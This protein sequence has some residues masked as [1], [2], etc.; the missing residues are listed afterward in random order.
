MCIFCKIINNEIPSNKI[1]EDDEILAILD[2]SQTEVGGHKG[3][4]LVMPKKHYANVLEIPSDELSNIMNKVQTLAKMI[5]SKLN[6]SGFNIVINTNE[7]AGQTVMHLHVH[8]IPRYDEKC[9][10]SFTLDEVM[11]TIID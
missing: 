8:I 4:T 10:D 2:I 1:Y 3:H 5:T 6:A 7:S 11:H 9:E